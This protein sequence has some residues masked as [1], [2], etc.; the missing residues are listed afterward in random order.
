[1]EIFR[2]YPYIVYVVVVYA[3]MI[4][5][6]IKLKADKPAMK[7]LCIAAVSLVLFSVTF[8]IDKERVP[9]AEEKVEKTEFDLCRFS[10]YRQDYDC[11]LL[12]R[13]FLGTRQY[14]Y[15]YYDSKNRL[16]RAELPVNAEIIKLPKSEYPTGPYRVEIT[17]YSYMTKFSH[18]FIS[19]RVDY[20]IYIPDEQDAVV[21]EKVFPRFKRWIASLKGRS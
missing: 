3:S 14:S 2:L 12:Y 11:W 5:F 16:F 6:V 13:D 20:S 9:G 4:L 15:C 17:T 21:K 19:Y 1:M 8:Q 18:Q 7:Y 10:K